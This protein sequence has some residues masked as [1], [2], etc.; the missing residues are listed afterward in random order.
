M[1]R[2]TTLWPPWPFG[3]PKWT[4]VLS[5]NDP[6]ASGMSCNRFNRSSDRADVEFFERFEF[7]MT[8]RNAPGMRQLVVIIWESQSCLGVDVDIQIMR[9]HPGLIRL[10]GK[11]DQL[12]VHFMAL[13]I[14]HRRLFGIIVTCFHGSPSP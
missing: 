14:N 8:V 13:F 9:D 1:G 12:H 10:Q 4:R 5:S 3:L 6:P 2:F 11:G 7:F